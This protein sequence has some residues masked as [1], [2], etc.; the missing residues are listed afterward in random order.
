MS[1]VEKDYSEE[2]MLRAISDSAGIVQVVADRLR[3][4]W[5]TAR[6]YINKY[7]SCVQAMQD[8]R[9]AVIDLAESKLVE[10]L[11]MGR[12][13]AIK[14]TLSTLGK[15]RGYTYRLETT[16]ADGEPLGNSGPTINPSLCSLEELKLLRQIMRRQAQEDAETD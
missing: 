10:K 13:W 3:C 2:V 14:Y 11:S 4:T 12:E 1:T 8:E 9:E 15:G 6:K 7:P 5:N 16:G